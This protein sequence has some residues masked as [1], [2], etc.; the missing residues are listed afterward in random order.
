MGPS[1]VRDIGFTARR[2]QRGHQIALLVLGMVL[3][4]CTPPDLSNRLNTF[5]NST[6]VSIPDIHRGDAGSD[7]T[8][9]LHG[10]VASLPRVPG[11]DWMVVQEPEGGEYSGIEVYLHH[12]LPDLQVLPGDT[13]SLTADIASRD[14]R[15]S[16]I[17]D[18]IDAIEVTGS[19]PL[20]P[21]PVG[22]LASWEP[23]VGVLVEAESL[24]ITDCGGLGGRFE[25]EEGP[26]IDLSYFDA[27]FTLG[28]GD[29]LTLP[30]GVVSGA[31]DN[32]QLTPRSEADLANAET[33]RLCPTTAVSARFGDDA[34]FLTLETLIV[35]AVQPDGQR[36]FVQDPYGGP[37]SGLELHFD[38]EPATDLATGF[39]IRAQGWLDRADGRPILRVAHREILSRRSDIAPV[40]DIASIDDDW[41][42]W[43]GALVRWPNITLLGSAAV[44]RASTDI[45]VEM[46]DMLWSEEDPMPTEG[47]GS[48]VGVMQVGDDPEAFVPRL[49]PRN[50]DDIALD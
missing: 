48:V 40:T 35:T 25:T 15:R 24:T 19:L 14:G 41:T 18:K 12:P 29:R 5:P 30:V 43:D 3:S 6:L 37:Y 46:A 20:A 27:I 1:W 8:V 4:A 26:A 11:Q 9:T 17:V 23:F 47:T 39:V 33:Y 16:L 21:T 38:N 32:H 2:P 50:A 28:R 34:G 36:V 45:G 31:W 49:F 7:G 42:A 10:V 13:L 22:T 44:G